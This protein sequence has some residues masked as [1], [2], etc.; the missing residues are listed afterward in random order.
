MQRVAEA[1]DKSDSIPEVRKVE[2]N[3]LIY[4]NP[5]KGTPGDCTLQALTPTAGKR[6][7]HPSQQKHK[8]WNLVKEAEGH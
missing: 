5:E 3:L 4:H 7:Q 1:L 2:N 8:S 6:S